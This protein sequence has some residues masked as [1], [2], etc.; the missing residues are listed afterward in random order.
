MTFAQACPRCGEEF[1]GDDRDSV[2]DQV[3]AHAT[4]D[5]GHALDRDIVL[6]HL[7]GRH[8]HD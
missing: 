3:V 2:A 5:H 1:A 8:P 7:D 6:A 4:D